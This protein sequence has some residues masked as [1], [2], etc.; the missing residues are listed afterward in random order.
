MDEIVNVDWSLQTCVMLLL[1]NYFFEKMLFF[2]KFFVKVLDAF[3][4]VVL[5][6]SK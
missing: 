3:E 6:S 5:V 1:M 2:L 4:D